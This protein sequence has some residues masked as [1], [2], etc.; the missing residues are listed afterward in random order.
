M[1]RREAVKLLGGAATMAMAPVGALRA[2]GP[3]RRDWSGLEH[4][5]DSRLITPRSPLQTCAEAGGVGADV[6]FSR[7]R[8]PYYLGDEPALTQ[9]LGWTGAW[10]SRAS[11]RAVVAQSAADIAAAVNF[12]RETGTRIVV[13]GGGHSYFGNS[14]AADSLLVWTRRMDEVTMHESFVPLGA[15]AGHPGESAVSVGAGAIW[16]R[17]YDAVSVK[18]G[19]YV[20][21]GG[22]LTVGVA[23][24]VQ[25]GGF[26]SLS[27]QFGTGAANLLE[28]QV[29]TSDGRIRT[30]NVWQDPELF[31]ALKGGGG[32]TFG[33]VTRLTLRTHELPTTI[34]AVIFQVKASDD[35]AWR[36]LVARIVAFYSESLF[37]PT[38][39]EQLRFAPDRTLSVTM[40]FHGLDDAAAKTC[41]APFFD[42]VRAEKG[43]AVDGEPAVLALPARQFWDA[44]LLSSIPGL[45]GRDDRPGAPAGNIFWAANVDEAGQVLNAYQSAWIPASLLAPKSQSKLVEAIV[46]GSA[47]W[48]M[49]LHT[50]K[51]LAGCS[52]TAREL[53]SATATNPAMLEAFALLICAAESPPAWPGIPGHEPDLARGRRRAE[54]VAKAMVPIRRLL[55]DAGA[56]MSEADYYDV[57]WQ[58]RYWGSNYPRLLAAKRRYDPRNMFRGHHTVGSE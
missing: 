54:G 56:Y 58:R 1:N 45:V 19:R 8:N 29:V 44:G 35:A 2:A 23:G 3:S 6:L 38:W 39:G 11:E 13:K 28:A 15:P 21:G 57:D 41:W 31:Y 42:W 47:E 25:G 27:K 37:N 24:F 16:G 53:S 26:G 46:E 32:G 9:T 55:P 52:P 10:T 5:L 49:T 48:T 36:A 17:V 50:N 30:V 22:C 7:L 51:G 14:N 34:G 12:A 18:G 40:V 43:V 33:I 20:Q 4:R